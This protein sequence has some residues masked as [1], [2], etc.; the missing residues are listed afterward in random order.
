M[1]PIF[2]GRCCLLWLLCGACLALP[3]HPS[4]AAEPTAGMLQGK[5]AGKANIEQV[6]AVDRNSGKSYRGQLDAANRSFRI[7][8]IPWDV[9]V[10][11]RIDLAGARLEGINLAV[12]ASDYEE[13][14][15]LVEED[16][17]VI[18]AK[19]R[20][21]NKFEDV[22][23]VLAVRGNIQHAAVLV[24]KL[25]TRPFYM[26]KPGEVVW[27]AELWHFERPDENWLK[28]QDELAIV[29]YRERIQQSLYDKRAITFDSTLGGLMLTAA[30][31]T[32]DL[33][34]LEPPDL[35]PGIRIRK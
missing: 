16:E 17:A 18:K 28:V 22:V 20:A 4:S 27:R 21:L 3:R 5:V 29:L 34:E 11:C 13:E 26:S 14:Q 10:D 33:G 15:P 2:A 1:K 30:E 32:R 6:S 12:P 19:V 25:R 31:P 7:V 35:K 23:D 9:P 8:G 24:N